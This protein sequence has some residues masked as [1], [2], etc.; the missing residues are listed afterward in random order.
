MG[1]KSIVRLKKKLG[2]TG[3]KPDDSLDAMLA[4]VRKREEQH[5]RLEELKKRRKEEEARRIAEIARLK[6][7][8][9]KRLITSLEEDILKYKEIVSSPYGKDLKD[10]AWK[11]LVTKYLEDT[12]DLEIGDT[13]ELRFKIACSSLEPFTNSIGMKFVYV[14]PGTFI[15][16]SPTDEPGRDSDERQHRVTLSKDFYIQITE[17][18]Q[19]QWQAIMGHNPSHFKNCGNNCPVE[20]VSWNDCQE[21]IRRLNQKEKANK[22]RLSTEAEWEYACRAGSTTPFYYGIDQSMLSNHAW[23]GDVSRK[24]TRPVGQ[25]KPNAWGLY[26]MHG[27]VWEWCQDWY[28]EYPTGYVIDPKRPSSG[29]SRVLRGG[30]WS[31]NARYCRSA[32]RGRDN[33]DNRNYFYGFRLARDL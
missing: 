2:E 29:S 3:A 12:G 11:S 17:V 33:P 23:Y 27:N 1:L 10:A 25:K 24:G 32:N 22:Y 18:T 26:D 9:R 5:K 19:R 15:M 28:G 31:N 6:E 16:G 13:A 8:R 4:L 21:F 30:G 20:T 7:E 14:S